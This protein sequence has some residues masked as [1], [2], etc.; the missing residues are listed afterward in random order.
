[1]RPKT[2][3]MTTIMWIGEGII[4]VIIWLLIFLAIPWGLIRMIPRIPRYMRYES[5]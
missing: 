3:T 5:L 2:K 4:G 1:M